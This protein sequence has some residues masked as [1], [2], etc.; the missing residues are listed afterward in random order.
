MSDV[1]LSPRVPSARAPRESR[2]DGWSLS[3]MGRSTFLRVNLSP[4]AGYEAGVQWTKAEP[5]ICAP[6]I[7]AY[8]RNSSTVIRVSQGD[9]VGSIHGDQYT[10]L[11]PAVRG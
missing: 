11:P 2:Q 5:R 1:N 8:P 3:P 6:M 9:Y 10:I 4:Q 7:N